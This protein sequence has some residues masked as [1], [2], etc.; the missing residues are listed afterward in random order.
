MCASRKWNAHFLSL[1]QRFRSTLDVVGVKEVYCSPGLFEVGSIAL[2]VSYSE[3]DFLILK[4]KLRA[5][6]NQLQVVGVLKFPSFIDKINYIVCL[7]EAI[8][9]QQL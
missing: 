7:L 9:H 3:C 4:I 1:H 5:H 8:R 6:C 2:P